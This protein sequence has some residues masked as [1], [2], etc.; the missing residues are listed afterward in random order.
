MVCWVLI[1]FFKYPLALVQR[2]GHKNTRLHLGASEETVE[3]I[4][5]SSVDSPR[6]GYAEGIQEVVDLDAVGENGDRI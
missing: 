4:Q 5:V 2:I 1:V 3:I 6:Y